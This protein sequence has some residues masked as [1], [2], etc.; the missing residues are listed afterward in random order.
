MME[1]LTQSLQ[2]FSQR[3]KDVK[4]YVPEFLKSRRPEQNEIDLDKVDIKKPFEY[5]GEEGLT[6]Y[7]IG[8]L[9]DE[10]GWSDE[11]ISSV[12]T[13]EH[14][15]S[16]IEGDEALAIRMDSND[17]MVERGNM[18]DSVSETNANSETEKKGLTDEENGR[19]KEETAWSDEI[20]D[21]IESM[22]QYE[23]YRNANFHE[24]EINGRKCLVKDIDFDYVDSKTG[25][26]NRELM[27]K[28]R[29]PIDA[30][31]G[32]KIELHHMGQ[33][34]DAPFAELCENSEHGD[35]N[36]STLHTK[37]SDSW[38][39]DPEQKNQYQREKKEHWQIRA[40]EG[41]ED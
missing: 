23:I 20:I 11:E 14:A 17:M 5:S 22:E 26:T 10:Y 41:G 18:A 31:T 36:H 39:N 38:R 3:I 4:E 13:W 29:S 15:E 35:G 12:K 6:E 40:S 16:I 30:K 27:A 19:I 2:E 8:I 28:G 24:E 37:T 25:M 32:E 21:R 33:G 1:N 34:F 7:Q 9:K